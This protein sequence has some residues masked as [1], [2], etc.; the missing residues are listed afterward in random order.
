MATTTPTHRNTDW[1]ESVYK[2]LD[3][4]NDVYRHARQLTLV[5]AEY[6][7]SL[8]ERHRTDLANALEAYRTVA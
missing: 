3:A 2:R 7:P 8:F 5:M 6:A 1:D 4:L